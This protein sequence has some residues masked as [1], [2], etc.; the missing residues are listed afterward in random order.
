MTDLTQFGNIVCEFQTISGRL[1]VYRRRNYITLF[2]ANNRHG[3]VSAIHLKVTDAGDLGK[4]LIE[5]SETTEYDEAPAA[6]VTE[7][8]PA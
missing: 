7:S 3:F 6:A 2:D 1:T 4:K 5:A 8:A